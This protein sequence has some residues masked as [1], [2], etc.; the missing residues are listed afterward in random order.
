[1]N[2]ILLDDHRAFR[3]ALRIALWQE[4]AIT[5]T[6]EAATARE[7][8][9]MVEAQRPDLL[10]ADLMLSD[11]DGISLVRELRRRGDSTKVMI[12]TAHGNG[13]FVRDAF[14]VG[15][16][17]YAL[18]DQAL[19]EIVDAIKKTAAGERYVAP[20]LGAVPPAGRSGSGDHAGLDQ[21]SRRER[22]IFG[23]II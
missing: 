11:T 23:R 15:V 9:P 20:Q 6:G 1:M 16:G 5:V 22:E 2:I 8:V 21:L 7:G 18:K 17:G 4:A 3:D 19:S 10:V 12:L 14:D 13:L